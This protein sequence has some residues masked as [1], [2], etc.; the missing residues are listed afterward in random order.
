MGKGKRN[1]KDFTEENPGPGSYNI[2]KSTFENQR[3]S[4]NY[5]KSKFF[6]NKTAK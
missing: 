2:N 5:F 1:N 6:P 3:N 4:G